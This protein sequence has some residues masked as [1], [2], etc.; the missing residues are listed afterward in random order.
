MS[1][2]AQKKRKRQHKF[3]STKTQVNKLHLPMCP[4]ASPNES[5]C[6]ELPSKLGSTEFVSQNQLSHGSKFVG[7]SKKGSWKM[8]DRTE[9]QHPL[10]LAVHT[11]PISKILQLKDTYECLVTE[12]S[13]LLLSKIIFPHD[14]LLFYEQF[15]EKTPAVFTRAT[16][17]ASY[18]GKFFTKKAFKAM[19][20]EHVLKLGIDVDI[21]DGEGN[22]LVSVTDSDDVH[23][24][25]VTMDGGEIWSN[26]TKQHAIALLQPQVYNDNIWN[27][28][29]SLEYEFGCRVDP[30]I[31][32]QPSQHKWTHPPIKTH[33]FALQLEGNTKWTL[34]KDQTY[35]PYISNENLLISDSEQSFNLRAGD[36][37]YIPFGWKATVETS[38]M[39][40]SLILSLQTSNSNSVSTLFKIAV[41]QAVENLQLE[42]RLF[43][44]LLPPDIRDYLGVPTS[45]N[46]DDPKRQILMSDLTK[47]C[48][49]VMTQAIDII[50]PAHDQVS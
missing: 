43:R 14:R 50:D 8:F 28:C 27:L 4:S 34:K 19:V 17:D 11:T 9:V 2:A 25:P 33:Q 40:Q 6:D 44:K 46:E 3:N 24:L 5:E 32:L 31:T 1:R 22:R 20:T 23:A 10:S 41:T 36:S 18:F 15:W 12:K 26:Y 7:S 13:A 30:I 39:G 35:Q 29:S 38:D 48:S 49:Q 42:S 21:I 16:V 45:E 47:L 37:L